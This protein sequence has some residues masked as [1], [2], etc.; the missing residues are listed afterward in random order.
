MGAAYS[1]DFRLKA[2]AA[3]ERGEKKSHVSRMFGISRNTLNLWLRRQAETGS[4]EPKRYRRGPTPKISE[5]DEFR[6]F[7]QE[8]G[9]LT[10]QQMAD[11]WPT[12]VSNRTVGKALKA[13]GYTR[14][15]DL[16]LS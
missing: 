16:W 3:V 8:R 2:V 9:H 4:I 15:K 13:I 14:K 12:A 6:R 11:E 7:A 10:Q 1:I 5:L